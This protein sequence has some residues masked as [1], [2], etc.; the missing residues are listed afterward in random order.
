[1]G[2]E[3]DSNYIDVLKL[4][5][6]NPYLRDPDFTRRYKEGILLKCDY[7]DNDIFKDPKLMRVGQY[8]RYCCYSCLTLY[9]KNTLYQHLKYN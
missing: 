2:G 4:G 3:L 8:E 6:E 9:N 5:I 7:Y 1:M